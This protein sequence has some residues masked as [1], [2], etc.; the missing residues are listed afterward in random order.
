METINRSQQMFRNAMNEA[1]SDPG[2]AANP[3]VMESISR[4]QQMF[5]NAMNEETDRETRRF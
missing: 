1:S 5:R 4:L 2:H 3:P